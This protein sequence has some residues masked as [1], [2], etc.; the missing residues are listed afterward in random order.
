MFEVIMRTLAAG[1]S[2][3]PEY[4]MGE[5]PAQIAASLNEGTVHLNSK[6][7][8]VTGTSVT[9][10]TGHTISAKAVVVAVEGPAAAQLLN[11][12]PIASRTAGCVYFAADRSPIDGAYV[13]LDADGSGPVANVAVM[14]N[15]SPAYA[16]AGK[17]LIAAAMPGVIDGDLESLARQQ[18]RAW[19]GSQVDAWEHLRTYKIAHGQPD[20]QPPF[21][22]KKNVSLGG[23]LFVCGDH[24]DTGSIQGALFSGRRCAESVVEWVRLNP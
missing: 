16:P 9:T 13:V 7:T 2:A 12:P 23:G 14:S 8:H 17:H 4:G 5:I 10:S 15:I 19:W 6:A 22:P 3:V 20:Q 21:N 24:R 1:S 11:I 18:L